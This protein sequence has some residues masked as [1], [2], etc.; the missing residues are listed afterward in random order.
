MTQKIVVLKLSSVPN[1][2]PKKLGSR[3]PSRP[4]TRIKFHSKM[5][6][7]AFDDTQHL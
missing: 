6:I 7:A 3:R 2:I 1:M 5:S 4:T